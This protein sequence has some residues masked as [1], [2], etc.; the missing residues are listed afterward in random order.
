MQNLTTK[1]VFFYKQPN[2]LCF[3]T[4]K[5]ERNS[6]EFLSWYPEPGSNRHGSESTGV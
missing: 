1:V 2:V 6:F 4:T 3:F 5:K